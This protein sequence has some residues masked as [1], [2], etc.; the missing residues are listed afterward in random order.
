MTSDPHM[1]SEFGG[2]RF[3]GPAFNCPKVLAYQPPHK[4]FTVIAGPCSVE[5]MIQ[6]EDLAKL[7]SENGATHLRGGI[8]RAGTYPGKAFGYVDIDLVRVFYAEAKKNGLKNIIEVLDY[9][10]ASLDFADDY[11]DCFQVGARSQQNYTLLRKLGKY[12]KPVFLKRHPGSTV[13]EWL[14]SAEHLLAGGVTELYLIERGSSTFHTDVRWTPCVHTIPSVQSMCNIPVIMDAS[15]GS[16]RRDI[17]PAMTLAGVAAGADGILLE[18][19]QDPRKSLSDADQAIDPVTFEKLMTKV[20]KI[21]Q[22]V[23]EI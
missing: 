18:V 4:D 12:K 23:K 1:V 13:D 6:I 7:V 15:H 2:R 11:S 20:G 22:I 19:H 21:R 14:G 8:F 17:V 9:D 5:S 16:G 10:D 3:W